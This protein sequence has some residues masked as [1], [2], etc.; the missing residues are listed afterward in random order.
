MAISIN[1]TTIEFNDNFKNIIKEVQKN[2]QMHT[3][4]IY[5]L[6]EFQLDMRTYIKKTYP[7]LIKNKFPDFFSVFI[8]LTLDIDNYNNWKDVSNKFEIKEVFDTSLNI[9][10]DLSFK[11]ACGHVIH[12][13]NMYI[14][15]NENQIK[16]IN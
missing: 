14:V 2:K 12:K 13:N 1:K 15:F 10:D 16:P 7:N 11:C 3:N 6:L 8:A 5:D 9:P 4:D